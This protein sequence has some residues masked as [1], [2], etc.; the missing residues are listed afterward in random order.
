M[1]VHKSGKIKNWGGAEMGGGGFGGGRF[2]GGEGGQK[3][4]IFGSG[5]GM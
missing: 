2:G 3:K 4:Y 1:L 5:G